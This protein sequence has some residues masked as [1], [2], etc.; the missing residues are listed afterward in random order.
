MK[1]KKK[2]I[3]GVVL[4]II[5]LFILLISYIVIQDLKIEYAL[6]NELNELTTLVN[7]K[8]SL[9]NID[10]IK[11]KLT[12]YISKNEYLIVEK[13]YK[14]YLLDVLEDT[15][16][17]YQITN[18]EKMI[19]ILTIQNIQNDGKDFTNT[20]NY[21]TT[22]KQTLNTTIPHL[23]SLFEIDTINSYI[24]DKELDSYYIEF[25]KTVSYNE[26]TKDEFK[27]TKEN[28]Q[29]S[30]DTFNDLLD[31]YQEVIN[32]LITNK[33]HYEIKDNLIYFDNQNLTDTY[34]QLTAKLSE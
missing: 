13:A 24:E 31:V 33:D 1:N 7:E 10:K 12:N 32:F 4:G 30:L 17:V 25:F 9:E 6:K 28:L 15:E 19:N 14:D 23:I 18:D 3:L 27:E 8:D 34:N 20:N 22:T 11:N 26:N 16:I 5:L 21:L 29:E 2:I